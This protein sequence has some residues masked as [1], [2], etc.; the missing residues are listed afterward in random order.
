MWTLGIDIAK[1]KHVAALLDDNGKRVFKNFSF[2]N[3]MEGVNRLLDRINQVGFS[4]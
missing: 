3:T 4:I 1:R 2:A